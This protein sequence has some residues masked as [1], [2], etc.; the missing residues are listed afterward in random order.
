MKN[1][2]PLRYLGWSLLLFS[3]LYLFAGRP[4]S[5]IAPH[6][7]QSNTAIQQLPV[8]YAKGIDVSHYQGNI[9]WKEVLNQDVSFAYIKTT[10]GITYSDPKHKA[11]QDALVK[12]NTPFGLYHFFEPKD[13]GVM[14]ANNFLK[15]MSDNPLMLPPVLDVEISKGVSTKVIKKEVKQWLDAVEKQT[16]CQPIIYSYKDY[17]DEHLGS[18]FDQY[19]LWLADYAKEPSLPKNRSQWTFWQHSQK[20]SLKGIRGTVDLNWFQ[21]DRADLNK[22]I[23]NTG[24]PT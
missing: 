14:Q 19:D 16:G 13:D 2:H 12:L 20:G 23:C 9:D 4:A 6:K 3:L 7:I 5:P 11:N 1:T 18:E 24:K 10:D 17:Y 15:Q 22:L 21:G 8:P